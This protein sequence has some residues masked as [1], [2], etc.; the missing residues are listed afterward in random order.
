MHP[1]LV[2]EVIGEVIGIFCGFALSV[3]T[4]RHALFDHVLM[5]TPFRP[6]AFHHVPQ[7]PALLF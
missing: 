2:I 7:F 3:H 6:T 1:T 4:S 5:G